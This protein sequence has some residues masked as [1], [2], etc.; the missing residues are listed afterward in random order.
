MNKEDLYSELKK[1]YKDND[2]DAIQALKNVIAGFV[3]AEKDKQKMGDIA[4]KIIKLIE[5]EVKQYDEQIFYL[6]KSTKIDR[7]E[8]IAHYNK[9]KE[10][11]QK[12]LPT[13]MSIE[14]LEKYVKD[15]FAKRPEL[16]D[17]TKMG[18]IFKVAKSEL[19]NN[20]DGK[21]FNEIVQKFLN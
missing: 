21:K 17:K 1:A 15:L 8:V 11:L 4:D 10:F 13:K 12:Y 14:E 3:N 2:K 20:F 18:D 6:K 7:D 9:Q 16:L 19:G 5:K